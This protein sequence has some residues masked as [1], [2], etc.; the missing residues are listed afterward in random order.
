MPMHREYGKH[1]HCRIG[2]GAAV[3]CSL[4]VTAK[5]KVV[6]THLAGAPHRERKRSQLE[7]LQGSFF[8]QGLQGHPSLFFF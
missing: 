4:E 7:D 5:E 1:Q 3:T 8:P 2:V 6:R